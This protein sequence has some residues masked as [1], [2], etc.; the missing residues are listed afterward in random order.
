LCGPYKKRFGWLVEH[1][2]SLKDSTLFSKVVLTGPDFCGKTYLL[3]Q[4]RYN[5]PQFSEE[6]IFTVGVEFE[7]V[8]VYDVRSERWITLQI[9]DTSG[10]ER[11]RTIS[12][13]IYR[14]SAV[15]LIVYLCSGDLIAYQTRFSIASRQS[16]EKMESFF[17]KAE[18]YKAIKILVGS[19][20][21]K[22]NDRQVFTYEAEKFA[23]E[24]GISYMEV[25]SKTG[26]NVQKLLELI[27][28]QTI[29]QQIAER[30]YVQEI[31]NITRTD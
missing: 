20:V 7:N 24:R 12:M 29:N 14:N 10:L 9:W 18:E 22:E 3:N 19:Q 2:H 5:P 26:Q 27:A 25:S 31:E 8:M 11:F 6:Y 30:A 13:D 21:D 1:T 16:F 4:W 17:R 15:I 23:E 28:S